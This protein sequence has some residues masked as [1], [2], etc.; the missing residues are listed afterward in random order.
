MH[1]ST[2]HYEDKPRRS[3]QKKQ[4]TKKKGETR[5]DETRRSIEVWESTPVPAPNRSTLGV[6]ALGSV[7]ELCSGI[8][9]NI[10]I[11]KDTHL[12]YA[13]SQCKT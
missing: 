11:N 12:H 10:S 6:V 7:E 9:S 1:K 13:S 4:M 2:F 8:E 5:R 3:G